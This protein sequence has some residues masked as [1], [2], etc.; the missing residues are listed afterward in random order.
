MYTEFFTDKTSIT[1]PEA[2]FKEMLAQ[3][4]TAG[5]YVLARLRGDEE[6]IKALHFKFL[7]AMLGLN[8]DEEARGK[9]NWTRTIV[10]L[11]PA[12]VRAGLN[13]DGLLNLM[14]RKARAAWNKVRP[15]S[16]P[17]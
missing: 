9:S 2:R 3:L 4:V 5:E 15:I 8:M 11:G 1:L 16:M 6:K 13:P 7:E 17:R 10:A 12:A 14:C